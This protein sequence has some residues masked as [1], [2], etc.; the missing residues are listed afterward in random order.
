MDEL[1]Q[2][3]QENA[4]LLAEIAKLKGVASNTLHGF[5]V[6]MK[7]EYYYASRR[8]AG[9]LHWVYLGKSSDGATEKIAGYLQQRGL[10]EFSDKLEKEGLPLVEA[11]Q[12]IVV[13]LEVA[14]SQTKEYSDLLA[15]SLPA[16]VLPAIQHEVD[17]ISQQLA[18]LTRNAGEVLALSEKMQTEPAS[19][20]EF[21]F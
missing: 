14:Q 10:L 17:S 21:A 3:R 5:T 19:Q 4:R 9:K 16:N 1:E 8:I 11:L 13:T 18:F 6:S 7:G 20:D 12:N 2:L 15:A